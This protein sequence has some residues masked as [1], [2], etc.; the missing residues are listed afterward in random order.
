MQPFT[1]TIRTACEMTGLAKT[2][3]YEFIGAGKLE[4]TVVRRRRLIKTE[5]L[6]ALL[7]APR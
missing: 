3:I 1:I 5:S 7:A 2:K 6:R 4:T